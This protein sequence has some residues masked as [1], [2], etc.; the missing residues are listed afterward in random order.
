[1]SND[2]TKS[3]EYSQKILEAMD[4]IA[5][6]KINSISFD[7]TITCTITNDEKRKEGEYE[8]SNGISKFKAYS[9]DNS[10]R[11]D[12][13]VYVTIPEGNYDNQKMIIGKKTDEDIKPYVFQ[14]P[15]DT[16]FDMTGNLAAAD[17]QQPLET[18]ALLANDVQ[19]NDNGEPILIEGKP[20]KIEGGTT[21]HLGTLGESEEKKLNFSNY[22]R[23]GIKADFKTW[24]AEAVQGSYGLRL[25]ITT[26]APNAVPDKEGKQENGET[27]T[28]THTLTFN[29]SDMYGN[30][31][32][33]ETF[34]SQEKVF[35]IS[36]FDKI[37]KIEIYF[38]QNGD[39]YDKQGNLISAVDAFQN[40]LWENLYVD[41]LYLCL[42]YDINTLTE[43]YVEIFTQDS[44]DYARSTVATETVEDVNAKNKKTIQTRWVHINDEGT[45]VDMSKSDDT[46]Y[47]IRWYRYRI[48]AAA[49]D[50]YS[51][52]YWEQ[53]DAISS[54]GMSCEFIPDTNNQQEKIKAVIL[55]NYNEEEET[56]IPYHSNEIIFENQETLPPGETAQHIANA[57][58]IIVDDGTNGNYLI[59]GQDNSIKD[60]K[61][62]DEVRTLS[63]K[64]DTNNDGEHE[65]GITDLSKLTWFFPTDNTMIQLEG[66]SIF[67]TKTLIGYEQGK[68]YLKN[69]DNTYSIS[70]EVFDV[71]KTYYKLKANSTTEYE[72]IDNFYKKNT[73]YKLDYIGQYGKIFQPNVD[74]YEYETENNNYK[75]IGNITIEQFNQQGENS[76]YYLQEYNLDNSETI[77]QG[78]IYYYYNNKN[79]IITGEV[80]KYKIR[81]TYSSNY[82]NN[83]ITCQ[84]I[85]NG[86]TYSSEIEFT[87]GSSGTMGTDQTL[88]IDFV[89]DTNAIDLDSKN[90]I[91]AYPMIVRIYDKEN[92]E[93]SNIGNVTWSWYYQDSQQGLT[94]SNS[95]NQTCI[96]NVNNNLAHEQL[97]IIKVK[98]GELETYYPIALKSGDASYIEGPTQIIYMSDGT[99]N[100]QNVPYKVFKANKSEITSQTWSI[101][102]TDTATKNNGI[103]NGTLTDNKLKPLGIY[104][105]NAPVYGVKCNCWTQ[106]IL[107]LQNRWS[108]NVLNAWDGEQLIIDESNGLILANAI[109][110]G[111]KESD[112]SFTGVII[113][114]WSGQDTSPA[115]GDAT[116]VYGFEHGAMSYAFRDNGTA[117]I[118][119]SGFGRIELDGNKAT[120][121]SSSYDK[122]NK[123]LKID[124]GG[125]DGVASINFKYKDDNNNYFIVLNGGAT[126]APLQIGSGSAP[127]FSVNW[128]GY[129][130]AANA[131]LEGTITGSTLEANDKSIELKGALQIDLTP[132]NTEDEVWGTLG[133]VTSNKADGKEGPGIGL[134]TGQSVI[135][136]TTENVGLAFSKQETS[137]DKTKECGGYF[138]IQNK[139]ITSYD[140]KGNSSSYT[141][142]IIQ[143]GTNEFLC[144]LQETFNHDAASSYLKLNLYNGLQY[145]HTNGV[146]LHFGNFQGPDGQY[147]SNG[148]WISGV[149]ASRQFGI[150]AR[151]A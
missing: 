142:N 73:Y 94:L 2:N 149:D 8:V 128:N 30:P 134:Y 61:W 55:Y 107:V 76:Q 45:P 10:Y 74:Y 29:V 84:Y 133:Y 81:K 105:K 47:Q 48:G 17:G 139:T 62:G 7:K 129:L 35:N 102:N 148:F 11:K 147:Y 18:G 51:G 101:V 19:V 41:N 53:S 52:V 77:T 46:N 110:A 33:Y 12:D 90:T 115:E 88:V 89:G 135:K 117:F 63:A 39:F 26:E 85:L 144:N 124:M 38:Y 151:F 119:K 9:Q 72:Q 146:K 44:N 150:Y 131:Y 42:G 71:N 80:P 97:Y 113:G 68:Y 106:P 70:N 28:T 120:L 16:I 98:V 109:S 143:M 95:T 20:V 114:D 21:V 43:D 37:T 27:T 126:S 25:K 15:F 59:Y 54:S 6:S 108:N 82:T 118:G 132:D 104:V 32:N 40:R 127:D 91:I 65:S 99:I 4:I 50:S 121:Q 112:N 116:G 87:F 22:T 23:L 60:T 136:A 130:Y 64:F 103:Y 122:S 100:Y 5:Q 78:R 111:K 96:I 56:G 145:C 34:Y 58:Q 1:M 13:V 79:N 57:L 123:G 69:E 137:F 31:Y 36:E 14:M 140:S 66:N 141:N 86:V 24:V 125:E 67:A 92:K 75:L 49:A 83:T 3:N 93:L 138:T